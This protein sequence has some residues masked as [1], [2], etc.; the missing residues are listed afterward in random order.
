MNVT[1]REGYRILITDDD[2]MLTAML[3]QTLANEGYRVLTAA[4]GNEALA[5]AQ[6]HRPDLVVLDW[7]MPGLSAST[8]RS[9]LSVRLNVTVRFAAPGAGADVASIGSISSSRASLA[10]AK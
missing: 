1:T 9:S 4:D 10:G 3:R 6:V 7:L 2:H 5:Q 8:W